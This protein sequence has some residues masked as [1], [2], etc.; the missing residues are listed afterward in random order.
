M[1]IA[2]HLA[3]KKGTWLFMERVLIAPGR[4]LLSGP[5]SLGNVFVCV[6]V[7]K[8]PYVCVDI[9]VYTYSYWKSEVH[10]KIPSSNPVAH[11]SFRPFCVCSSLLQQ[12]NPGR[13][14]P[15]CTY[16]VPQS[17]PM[18]PISWLL[19]HRPHSDLAWWFF[20][21]N[22]SGRKEGNTILFLSI[23]NTSC[24]FKSSQTT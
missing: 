22:Y 21:L 10:I 20:W 5:S 24:E 16:V 13:F 12:G 7:N 15:P 9:Y 2:N 3:G 1:L 6:S 11:P 23:L 14:S 17:S 19:S 8:H 4:L 18:S